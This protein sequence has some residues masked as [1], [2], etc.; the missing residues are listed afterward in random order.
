LG[1]QKNDDLFCFRR[2]KR[3]GQVLAVR[4]V[5][6]SYGKDGSQATSATNECVGIS[7][8]ERRLASKSARKK[9]RQSLLI[10]LSHGQNERGSL[11]E[12]KA[13]PVPKVRRFV[14]D[15]TGFP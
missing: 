1:W 13:N 2:R 3:E 6:R 12:Y 11:I 9:S 10:H 14:E 15:A 7:E 4:S 5:R 8:G